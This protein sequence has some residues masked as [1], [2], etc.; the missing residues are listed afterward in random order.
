LL[1]TIRIA[2][3]CGKVKQRPQYK[4]IC[5]N[6]HNLVSSSAAKAVRAL[7]DFTRILQSVNS[8]AAPPCYDHQEH[9]LTK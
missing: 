1:M 5:S 4:L 2:A 3:T 8:G 7:D 6:R 9:P